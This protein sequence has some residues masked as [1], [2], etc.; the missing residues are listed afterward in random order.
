[1]IDCLFI[2]IEANIYLGRSVKATSN[3]ADLTLDRP[4][5]NS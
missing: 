5:Y 2:K 4:P 3:K 1:M